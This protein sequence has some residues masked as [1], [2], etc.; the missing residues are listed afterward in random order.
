MVFW[1][2]TKSKCFT[3]KAGAVEASKERIKP[4]G[5][6][7]EIREVRSSELSIVSEGRL[8]KIVL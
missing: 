1:V 6:H 8:F 4:V 3:M 5:K 2:D 7:E